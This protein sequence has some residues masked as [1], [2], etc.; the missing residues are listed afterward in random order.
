MH[1]NQ[2]YYPLLV[3]IKK[4]THDQLYTIQTE[5]HT[6]SFKKKF[7]L[8]NK[9]NLILLAQFFPNR[10]LPLYVKEQ[11]ILLDSFLTVGN[12]AVVQNR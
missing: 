2:Q 5:L 12:L 3:A 8:T 11:N 6:I 10:F 9:Q 1:P 4:L 7:S